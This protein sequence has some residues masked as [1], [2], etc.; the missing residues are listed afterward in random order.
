MIKSRKQEAQKSLVIQVN[1]E[2]SYQELF[3]YCS[4]FGH[5]K[6][7]FHY[8][9]PEDQNNFIL[10]EYQESSEC[11]EALRNSQ[12]NEEN[13]GVP[14]VSPF[15]WF[16][17]LN[18]K[19]ARANP[20]NEKLMPRL[21][22]DNTRLI[23]DT[24][25]NEF[26]KS[27]ENLDDQMLILYRATCLS[28]LGTR[29]RFLASKQIETALIGMF[30]HVQAH[31]FGSSVNGFGKMGCDL[32]LIL[33]VG[34][35]THLEPVRSR[36]VFHTKV[37]LANE[38][39]QTQ[40]QMETIGDILHLFLPGVSNVRKI[41]QARVPIIKFNHECLD[42]EVDLSMSNLT[43]LYM[44]ELLYL[45]GEI[46]ERVKPLTFCI[47]RWAST[48]GITNPSP[49]RW[50]SNFSLTV[51]VI[52]FLQH[53]KTP[54]LPPMNLLVKSATKD[55]VRVADEKI[56]CTFLRDLN[57]LKF[58]R[59]NTDSLI[60]LLIQF[61]EFYSQFDFN[62]RAI[63]LLE[64]KSTIKP[65]H[66]AM[67]IVNPLEPLLNVSKNVSFEEVEKFKFEVKNA[68]WILE[69]STD[70]SHDDS[71]WGLLNL[72]KTNKQAIVK[73]QMFF[74]SRLVDVSDLFGDRTENPEEFIKF[75]NEKSRIE[76]N[77][78]RQATRNEIKKLETQVVTKSIKFKRR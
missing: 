15:L 10:F 6:E 52:F 51:L 75:K 32:D 50:I 74:K 76:V 18:T 1:S 27:A 44:S 28:D 78:I 73:P 41:L 48:T 2:N 71:S 43:G 21:R 53:L 23:P 67:W 77:A 37:S 20:D 31:P 70:K 68:A 39:S 34:R 66:S 13:A 40:R 54:I 25:L 22:F 60:Y 58:Q 30:P 42:L 17:A 16:K 45:L 55:D 46:D 35:D 11:E 57:N 61:F 14:V 26:L 36:L 59:E 8:K 65:D 69:S 47:R 7:A 33:R 5:I 64:G 4:Q 63:S 19:K 29:V 72:F 3:N 56:N 62:N 24:S 12:L 49:G 9:I 38:R